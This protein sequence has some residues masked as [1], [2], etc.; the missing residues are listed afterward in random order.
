LDGTPP[1]LSS[2]FCVIRLP[3]D[4]SEED[5]FLPQDELINALQRLDHNG[6]NT[7]NATHRATFARAMQLLISIREEILEIALGVGMNN[8]AVQ[9]P[10]PSDL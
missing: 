7:E 9:A 10:C 6:W 3:L 4:L 1:A 5:I 8:E 2:R